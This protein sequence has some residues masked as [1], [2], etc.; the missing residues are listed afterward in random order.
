MVCVGATE[1]ML[2]RRGEEEEGL[3]DE[4]MAATVRISCRGGREGDSLEWPQIFETHRGG[5][6]EGE[7]E[8]EREREGEG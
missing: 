3:T 2:G 1:L 7:G 4:S 5:E 8:G 6:G